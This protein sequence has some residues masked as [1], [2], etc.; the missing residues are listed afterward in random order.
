MNNRLNL[1]Y[2]YSLISLIIF[3]SHIISV[4]QSSDHCLEHRFN[5]SMNTDYMQFTKEIVNKEFAIKGQFKS[6][7]C[8]AKG[9]RNIEW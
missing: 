2:N 5:H 9:Y 3:L 8:C 6:L 7:H 4:V 1:G